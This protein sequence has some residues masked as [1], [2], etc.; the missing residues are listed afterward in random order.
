MFIFAKP[1]IVYT[2]C[3][4]LSIVLHIFFDIITKNRAGTMRSAFKHNFD[5]KCETADYYN[6][7]F[8]YM[9]RGKM[10]SYL[11]VTQVLQPLNLD[12]TAIIYLN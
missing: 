12:Y 5:Y 3:T 2:Y 4:L 6:R 11:S 9:I 7:P 10:M 1:K 8:R